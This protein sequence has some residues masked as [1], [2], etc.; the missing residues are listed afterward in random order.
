M[1]KEYIDREAFVAEMLKLYCAAC[2]RRQGIKNG[3]KQFLY[4]I[5]DVPCRACD[6][7][8]MIDDV[9]DFPAAD[10]APVVRGRWIKKDPYDS[11]SNVKCSA[12]GEVFDYIDGVCHLCD[13]ELPYYC[14]NCGARMEVQGDANGE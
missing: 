5:G 7:C 9:E 6:I 2:E 8:D 12:C 3:K 1:C 4:E 11:E 13:V 14:P 10:V